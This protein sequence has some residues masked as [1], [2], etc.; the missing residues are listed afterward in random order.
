MKIQNQRYDQDISIISANS[1]TRKGDSTVYFCPILHQGSEIAQSNVA[2]GLDTL[3]AYP[4]QIPFPMTISQV[5]TRVGTNTA[6]TTYRLGIYTDDGNGY[7]HKLVAFSDTG[8]YSSATTGVK[9]GVFAN[10]IKLHGNYWVVFN[11]SSASPTLRTFQS[12]NFI[13]VLGYKS[14]MTAKNVGWTVSY[15][16]GPMPELFPTGAVVHQRNTPVF[17][18]K[19]ETQ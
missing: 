4:M 18:F 10:R 11:S 3:N 19:T 5:V 6:A 15:T 17:A 12:N 8:T 16:Y 9:T 13:N 7:P 2:N 1:F 14:D